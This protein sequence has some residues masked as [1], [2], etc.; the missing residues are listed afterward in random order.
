MWKSVWKETYFNFFEPFQLNNDLITLHLLFG[1][2]GVSSMDKITLL[3]HGQCGGEERRGNVFFNFNISFFYELFR[4]LLDFQ[5][6]FF[7]S[8][9]KF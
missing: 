7:I 6:H 9:S 2:T 1:E 5:V 8:K 4:L 3:W